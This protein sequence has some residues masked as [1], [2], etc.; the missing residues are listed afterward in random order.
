HTKIIFQFRIPFYVY[1]YLIKIDM[2][3]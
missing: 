1:L 3:S 2:K